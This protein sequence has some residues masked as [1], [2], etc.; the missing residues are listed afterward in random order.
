MNMGS[1]RKG[2]A[3]FR[4]LSRLFM[5]ELRL[6]IP[7]IPQIVLNVSIPEIRDRGLQLLRRILQLGRKEL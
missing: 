5:I 3:Y 7:A 2:N 1:R 6:P 4:Y